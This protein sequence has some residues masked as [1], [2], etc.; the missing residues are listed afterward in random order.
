MAL[1][2]AIVFLRA[3]HRQIRDALFVGDGFGY[4]I[5]LPS[6]VIDHDLDLSNQIQHQ[7]A[8]TQHWTFEIV[9]Q[10]GKPGNV[11]QVGP[12]LL[13]FPFFMLAHVAL[14]LLHFLGM[15]IPRTGFGLAYE[16]PVYCGSFFYGLAGVWYIWCILKGHWGVR[17]ATLATG[18]IVLASPVAAYLWFEP[19]MSHILSMTLIA[20]LFYYVERMNDGSG[21][22]LMVWARIGILIGLIGLIRVPDLLAGITIIWAG[23]VQWTRDARQN[24]GLNW[25]GAICRFT[26][27]ALAAGVVFCPQLLA[28]KALYGRMFSIPPNPFYTRMGWIHPDLLNYLFSTFHG[29]FS[30]TPILFA[31]TVGLVCGAFRGPAIMRWSLAMLLVAVYFNSSIYRWWAGAS[32]G[33]RRMVDYAVLFALG[34]GYLLSLRPAL[35]SRLPVYIGALG[36]C[37]FNS[38]LMV[39]YFMHDLPEYGYVSWYDLYVTTLSF[40]LRIFSR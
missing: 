4:Y 35:L 8:Q 29:L 16:L 33:E 30:W 39:R 12:A 20:M 19:D 24:D 28:W 38:V 27:F 18:L 31:A 7:P 23:S 40:P 26:I 21:S 34:L 3:P 14:T 13:W 15:Q 5:Y 2:L 36:L 10:T 1:L 25:G 17:V 22:G 9:P 11:F 37:T 6:L 32:F